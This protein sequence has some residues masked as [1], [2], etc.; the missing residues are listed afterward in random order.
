MKTIPEHETKYTE[1]VLFECPKCE[2]EFR[3][4]WGDLEKGTIHTC[5]HCG[6]EWKEKQAS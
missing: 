1:T 4:S 3:G 6:Y 2:K 5:G